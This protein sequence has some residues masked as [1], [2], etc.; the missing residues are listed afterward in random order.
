MNVKVLGLV[1][2]GALAYLLA[3][4]TK[5]RAHTG[6]F[7]GVA[8]EYTPSP[9]LELPTV[10]QAGVVTTQTLPGLVL[11]PAV[12]TLASG[13][14][15]DVRSHSDLVRANDQLARGLRQWQQDVLE[16]GERWG[17][18]QYAPARIAKVLAG[19]DATGV[20]FVRSAQ[21]AAQGGDLAES[22]YNPLG[23]AMERAYI[24]TGFSLRI[25]TTVSLPGM[26][27]PEADLVTMRRA[28]VED[29][30]I[31]ALLFSHAAMAVKATTGQDI[32]R[33]NPWTAFDRDWGFGTFANRLRG[34]LS[35]INGRIAGLIVAHAFF[36]SA[37][38]S[39]GAGASRPASL[40]P[41]GPYL[42]ALVDGLRSLEQLRATE[43]RRF[44]PAP[45]IRDLADFRSRENGM[46]ARAAMLP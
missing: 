10:T 20:R 45:Q 37:A 27:N 2:A 21:Q 19:R 5:E 41:S 31:F 38:A 25:R 28:R 16:H 8:R 6:E 36:L 40:P 29:R 44:A 7:G 14:T 26:A 32:P 1:G 15:F 17:L 12:A 30:D 4:R 43:W 34:Q 39:Q 9:V 22:E 18:Q 11:A 3:S 42:A 24:A 46:L 33:D 23:L 13:Q 35:Q